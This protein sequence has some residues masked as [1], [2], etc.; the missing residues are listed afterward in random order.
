MTSIHYAAF[1]GDLKLLKDLVANGGDLRQTNDTGISALQFAAQGNQAAV[2]TYLLDVHNF[3]I[4]EVDAKKNS[5]LHWATYNS[6][7]LALSFLLA[8]KPNVNLQ[9]SEGI[10]PLH[11]AV[12]QSQIIHTTSI[13]RQLLMKQAN[14]L[15]R[16]K[17][18]RTPLEYA[19]EKIKDEDWQRTVV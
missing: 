5:S 19:R 15:S 4:D 14:P 12:A 8:R 18:G 9:D 6:N 17:K 13:I 7:E 10:T 2:I 11:L 3:D 1:N 16:D